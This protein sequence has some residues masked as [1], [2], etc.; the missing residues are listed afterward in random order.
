MA[1]YRIDWLPAAVEDL[2]QIRAHIESAFASPD[3]AL[4]IARGIYDAA[5]SL[6]EMPGRFPKDR[7]V[8]DFHVMPYRRYLLYYRLLQPE[9]RVEIAYIKHRLEQRAGNAPA[10]RAS[11]SEVEK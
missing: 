4:S 3:I 6:G 10:M 1:T 7:Q 8:P 2:R 11:I 5:T 9:K